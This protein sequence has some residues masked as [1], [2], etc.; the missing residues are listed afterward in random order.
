MNIIVAAS[1]V[2]LCL[3][4]SRVIKSL[5]ANP[6]RGGRPAK[7]SKIS[8]VVVVRVGVLDHEVEISSI[9]VAEIVVKDINMAAV[10]IIYSIKLKRES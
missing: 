6:V 3:I 1:R 7:D 8:I 10:I 4:N 5:G 9:F 2:A